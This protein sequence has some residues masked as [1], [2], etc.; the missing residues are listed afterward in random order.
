MNGKLFEKTS[1]PK[2]LRAHTIVSQEF[3][4]N[5]VPPVHWRRDFRI[6]RCMRGNASPD[7]S[8]LQPDRDRKK[9]RSLAHS[10][11][12]GLKEWRSNTRELI[13]SGI[14]SRDVFQEG[15]G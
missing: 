5:A 10:S 4:G 13:I 2:G 3:I 15:R 6:A 7:V 11:Y 9:G 14:Q 8:V 1:F 12:G